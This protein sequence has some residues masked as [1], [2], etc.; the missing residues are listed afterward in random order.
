MLSQ[1]PNRNGD[2]METGVAAAPDPRR[3][4]EEHFN[5]ESDMAMAL[6]EAVT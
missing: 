5:E 6:E 3:A 2:H 1:G 4:E